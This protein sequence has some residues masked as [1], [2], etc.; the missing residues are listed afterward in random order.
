MSQSGEGLVKSAV[1]VDGGGDGDEILGL[2]LSLSGVGGDVDLLEDVGAS[3]K[4]DNEVLDGGVALGVLGTTVRHA[5][6]EVEDE[7]RGGVKL[8]VVLLNMGAG[9]ERRKTKL[10]SSSLEFVMGIGGL[11]TL[12][13]SKRLDA[14]LVALEGLG[15]VMSV[16]EVVASLFGVL[17]E[18]VADG[19][20]TEFKHVLPFKGCGLGG[21]AKSG[22]SERS[23]HISFFQL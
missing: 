21:E 13:D 16:G 8:S 6:E 14:A 1:N 3:V 9:T 19:V 4:T 7:A 17:N 15:G 18:V 22:D 5:S 2:N 10:G 11:V 12:S 23:S 20:V